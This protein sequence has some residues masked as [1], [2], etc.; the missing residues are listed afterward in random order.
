MK[1]VIFDVDGTLYDQRKLRI[2]IISDM[3]LAVLLAPGRLSE[4]KILYHFRRARE[5][6]CGSTAGDIAWR[7]YAWAAEK[8]GCKPERVQRVVEKWMHVLPLKHLPTCR[9]SGASDVFH[10][11]KR[12]RVGI[13][14]F[15]DYPAEAK[16]SAMGLA[17]DVIV[18]AVDEDV[19]RLK[20][21][22]RGLLLAAEKLQTPVSRCLFIG[23][24]D[25]KDGECA[26]R[27]GM[28]CWIMDRPR[29]RFF[30][31]PETWSKLERWIDHAETD[32]LPAAG[33]APPVR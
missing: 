19:D 21:H 9:Y 13:G 3:F 29:S 12:R 5:K 11:L 2:R 33:P 31:R 14:V 27:A 23:D 15:S 20:P 26:R 22:P 28:L 32:S 7:Q 17:A 1:A 25:D 10:H 16:L 30:R 18:S 8:T 6:N 4:L 24:R